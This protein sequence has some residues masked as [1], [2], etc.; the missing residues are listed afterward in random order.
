MQTTIRILTSLA[1]LFSLSGSRLAQEAKTAS[2]KTNES[3]SI[4]AYVKQVDGFRKR[5][6]ERRRLFGNVGNEQ[7][8]WREFKGKVAKGQTQPEDLNEAAYVWT[9]RGKILA[10]GFEFQ[11]DSRDWGHFVTHYFRENGTLAKIHARLNTFYG[12]VTR[13]RDQYYSSNGKLLRTITRY[14][15]IQTQ[16]PKKQPNFQDEPIPIYLSVRRLPFY[17]LL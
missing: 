12:D 14:R 5:N 11:S 16:K 1:V 2:P 10:V 9:R 17:K 6:D 3:A 13:I 15:D 7:D 8:D 4:D